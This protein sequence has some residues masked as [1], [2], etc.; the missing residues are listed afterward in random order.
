MR[1]KPLPREVASFTFARIAGLAQDS[2]I[3][4]SAR[5]L[6]GI[7]PGNKEAD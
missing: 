5:C 6:E 4:D 1:P 7:F 2:D 3:G